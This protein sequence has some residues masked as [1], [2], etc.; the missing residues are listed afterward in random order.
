MLLVNAVPK[1]KQKKQA[2]KPFYLWNE[3]NFDPTTRYL[4]HL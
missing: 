4:L 3:M 2:H 1:K